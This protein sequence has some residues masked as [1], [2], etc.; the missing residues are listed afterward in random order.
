MSSF[1][2]ITFMKWTKL[3][4]A[5]VGLIGSSLLLGGCSLP[6]VAE[7]TSGVVASA[8]VPA[9]VYID[10]QHVGETPF[11]NA[12]IKS[13]EHVVK[14]VTQDQTAQTYEVEISLKPGMETAVYREFGATPQESSG[15]QL[16]LERGDKKDKAEVTIV[17][18]PTNAVVRLDDQ[19][20]GFAPLIN[21][22]VNPGEHKFTL[23]AQGYK[24]V[25]FNG[26]VNQGYRLVVTAELG[27]NY[28]LKPDAEQV[29]TP[30]ASPNP[31]PSP[32]PTPSATPKPSATPAP[33]TSPSP[34]NPAKPFIEVLQTPTGW[35]RVRSEPN[36]LGDNEV[37]RINSGEKFPF[38]ESN[39]SGWFKIEYEV[40]KT[41]WVAAQY[42]K[43]YK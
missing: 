22:E 20:K 31:S 8:S 14:L 43:L 19:P 23:N 3:L 12:K 6:L 41:G 26:T 29:A 30:S 27:K 35:L 15:Y 1:F 40:G 21:T 5:A 4:V 9:T 42:T 25:N 28:P 16:D 34:T 17:S 39:D 33:T 13:G 7:K 11:K 24:T 37:S 2:D 10:G 18:T 38:V 36:G 32:S